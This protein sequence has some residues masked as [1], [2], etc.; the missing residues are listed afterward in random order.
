MNQHF[1]TG[2]VPW[3]IGH[4]GA[5]GYAPENTLASIH[6]AA[7]IGAQ[8]VEFDVKL[9]ADLQPVLF[10]DTSLRRTSNGKGK[11]SQYTL[12][13][14]QQL[15]AGNWYSPDFLG[16]RIPS[17]IQA[18]EV[19]EARGLGAMI[20]LKPSPGQEVR[21]AEI[22]LRCLQENWP[23]SLPTPMLI[24]F[25]EKSLWEVKEHSAD[26]PLGLNF[27]KIPADWKRRLD[28]LGG[29]S[30]HC[31]H[32]YLTRARAEEIITTGTRLRCFTVNSA[33]RA[34]TLASWG[35]HGVFTNFPG[36]MPESI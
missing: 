35:V 27:R 12:P 31:R 1:S 7:D 18:I 36:R 25:S 17:L 34:R 3:V 4:R 20:E 24:S 5:C 28:R 29:N 14:L 32:Q 21:T 26:F 6:K 23:E 19:L 10:H 11:V 13:E 15:D 33:R 2:K 8:W 30:L 22:T 16:E 9:T